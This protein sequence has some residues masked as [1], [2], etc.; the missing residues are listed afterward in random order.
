VKSSRIQ[1][2]IDVIV[3]QRPLGLADRLLNCVE[4][5]GKVEARPGLA[6]H[7]DDLVQMSLGASEPFH[8]LGV[9]F[10]NVISCHGQTL[11]PGRGGWKIGSLGKG[12]RQKRENAGLDPLAQLG[13]LFHGNEE[14]LLFLG[15]AVRHHRF[16]GDPG[17]RVSNRMRYFRRNKS[18]V[19]G[20]NRPRA[21]SL[22][23]NRQVSF[24]EIEDFLG[25]RMQVPRGRLT[26]RKFHEGYD[27]LL[28]LVGLPKQIAP[29]NLRG[30]GPTLLVPTL[31]NSKIPSDTSC[32]GRNWKYGSH[33][34]DRPTGDM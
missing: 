24:D 8:N 34:Y 2:V 10:V 26:R 20:C 27:R 1:A 23:F 22:D 12:R 13:L 29:Q 31:S 19:A 6:E 16:C 14:R 9:G 17:T 21:L 18:D 3:D 15:S 32:R 25:T 4:L 7:L 11:S 30:L 28:D 33:P 5:L